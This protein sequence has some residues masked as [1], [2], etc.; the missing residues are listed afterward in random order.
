MSAR[1]VVIPAALMFV[2]VLWWAGRGSSVAP[3]VPDTIA[4][5]GSAS[6]AALDSLGSA[7]REHGGDD[8][9]LP[10][11]SDLED[12]SETSFQDYVSGKYRFL[13]MGSGLS[14]EAIAAPE[15]ILART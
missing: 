15:Q 7:R 6:V 9:T 10:A 4:S 2:A 11:G 1:G 8:E 5:A 13:F 12:T 14:P 3:E